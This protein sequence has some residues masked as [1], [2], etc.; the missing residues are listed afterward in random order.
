M[1][2]GSL[3][4][5]RTALHY[6]RLADFACDS[7]LMTHRLHNVARGMI[8]GTQEWEAETLRLY[9]SSH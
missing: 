6:A 9:W 2:P 5:T 8:M 3:W 7:T 4:R 1:V